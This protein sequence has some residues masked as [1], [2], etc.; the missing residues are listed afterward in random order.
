MTRE[1][2]T[3]VESTDLVEQPLRLHTVIEAVYAPRDW[4]SAVPCWAARFLGR[5]HRWVTSFVFDSGPHAGQWALL[6]CAPRSL[7]ACETDGRGIAIED[8]TD[9]S[10][11][12]ARDCF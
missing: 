2:F 9:R 3:L 4:D 6:P 10:V 8:L 12:G 1:R 5:R 7:D 11:L